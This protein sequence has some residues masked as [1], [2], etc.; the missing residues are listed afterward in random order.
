MDSS[1]GLGP[2]EIYNIDQD[3]H[4]AWN[5]T[6]AWP[7]LP[8][9]DSLDGTANVPPAMQATT[10]EHHTEHWNGP[11]ATMRSLSTVVEGRRHCNLQ[12]EAYNTPCTVTYPEGSYAEF[13]LHILGH[14][15]GAEFKAILNRQLKPKD[16]QILFT[17][18]RIVR[19]EEYVWR[20]PLDN[21]VTM[22]R[23]CIK[24]HTDGHQPYHVKAYQYGTRLR[25]VPSDIVREIM[26]A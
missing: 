14:H 4:A 26:K 7:T 12:L 11:G 20:C 24:Q 17:E 2:N 5:P 6:A 13:N 1:F 25:T 18:A 8:V 9:A 21:Y 10:P 19:A 3:A 16:A 15:I 22:R 23:S